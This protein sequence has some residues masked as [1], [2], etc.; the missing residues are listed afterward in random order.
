M[1][2][3]SFFQATNGRVTLSPLPPLC[4]CSI[5]ALQCCVSFW[6]RNI[7]LV[8][9]FYFFAIKN[10]LEVAVP[11]WVDSND[12]E[13]I[14]QQ[15]LALSAVSILWYRV[16]KYFLPIMTS[17]LAECFSSIQFKKYFEMLGMYTSTFTIFSNVF[18]FAFLVCFTK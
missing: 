9:C 14:Q 18:K 1:E 15:I 17:S 10:L 5:V 6:C 11:P 8:T 3:F 16:L 4:N 13:T 2:T 7:T 12:E